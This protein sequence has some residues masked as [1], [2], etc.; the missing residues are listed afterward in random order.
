[1]ENKYQTFGLPFQFNNK[2]QS[3]GRAAD[4]GA[5]VWKVLQIEPSFTPKSDFDAEVKRIK[6]WC[7]SSAPPGPNP[8]S[9][10]VHD[11]TKFRWYSRYSMTL[12]HMSMHS[13]SLTKQ[14]LQKWAATSPFNWRIQGTL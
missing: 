14:E 7:D 4:E 5:E 1:M 8:E 9:C 11:V 6:Q 2:M 10:I 12:L 3:S 13:A